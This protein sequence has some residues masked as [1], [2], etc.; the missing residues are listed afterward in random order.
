MWLVLL[1]CM[2]TCISL[3][4]YAIHNVAGLMASMPALL[5]CVVG[6][7]F[8]VDRIVLMFIVHPAINGC[9]A[10]QREAIRSFKPDVV[11][12]MFE[13]KHTHVASR[14]WALN[15]THSKLNFYI[16]LKIIG[17]GSSWGG[18]IATFLTM[19]GSWSGPTIL[20]APAGGLV[21]RLARIVPSSQ[22]H[23]PASVNY[24]H[25]VHSKADRVVPFQDSIDL[26]ERSLQLRDSGHVE[27]MELKDGQEL[28]L[29]IEEEC[30]LKR[31]QKDRIHLTL[32]DDDDHALSRTMREELLREAVIE[33][34][35]FAISSHQR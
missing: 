32:V 7:L 17:A 20:L 30:S 15:H 19:E 35:T 28:P 29:S 11:V 13:R 6:A 10:K 26:F 8:I 18:A 24:T 34:Y 1:A 33:A 22:L 23:I 12:G 3:A 31:Q 4:A 16:S 5:V 21:A 9:L 2:H 14:H 25:I 27:Q